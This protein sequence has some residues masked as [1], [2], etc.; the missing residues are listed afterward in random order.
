MEVFN[1]L[2]QATQNSLGSCF[3]STLNR[4]ASADTIV[5]DPANP[6]SFNRYSYVLNNPVNLIDPSGHS[7]CDILPEE[8]SVNAPELDPE[9][10]HPGLPSPKARYDAEGDY[11]DPNWQQLDFAHPIKGDFRV[12]NRH[13]VGGYIG[14]DFAATQGTGVY[15]STLGIVVVSSSYT[16]D[17][18]V[19]QGGSHSRAGPRQAR[20]NG[21]Y[22]NMLII[23]YGYDSLP[24]SVRDAYDVEE[25]QSIYF[26][27][28]HLQE[29][30]AFEAGDIVN[31][32]RR[33]GG[34]GSTRNST[35][36]H[37]H[38][39]MRVDASQ[40]IFTDRRFCNVSCGST[41]AYNAW[42]EL[43][44]EDPFDILE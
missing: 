36:S 4:F 14:G 29:P 22:G 12:T 21:G 15:T 33:I 44:T 41:D 24:Q 5:P 18:C 9:I 1:N 13:N 39:E 6:Q 43:T 23:E 38:L 27:Y 11:L 19:N 2:C 32:G 34:V 31:S 17:N 20:A 28:A 10:S 3:R 8:C 42:Q 25:D 37:L 16:L 40:Q 35:G 30:S 7:Y 26:L